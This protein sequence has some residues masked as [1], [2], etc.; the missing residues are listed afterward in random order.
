MTRARTSDDLLTDVRARVTAPA[1][2]GLLG[3]TE[4]L[5]LADEEMQTEISALLIGVR[6]EY[7][8]TSYTIAITSGV[9]SYRIP[10]RAAGMT[11]RDVTVYDANGNE[12]DANQYAADKRY[13]FTNASWAPG[14][15]FAFTLENGQLVL[16][17]TPAQSGYTL[18]L[19]YYS[20][21]SRLIAT[22]G[23]GLITAPTSTT[24]I[25]VSGSPPSTI[26]TT[27]ALVDIVRGDGMYEVLYE[28]RI[29]A[30]ELAGQI[31]FNSATPVVVSE[32][33]TSTTQNQRADYLCPSGYTVYPPIPDC[34]W[35]VLVSATCRAYCEAT[36]DMR[37]LEAAAV[38]FERR[39]KL[40]LDI[41]QPRVDS[42]PVQ[43]IP[44]DTPL[45]GS[46]GRYGWRW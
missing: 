27:G 21:P 39:K 6:S 12:W 24:V 37:G 22:S 8:L 18:R 36:A 7:W 31:T 42:Q 20:R 23:A 13:L 2:N 44:T 34:V 38:M 40:A 33:A 30:S 3:S 35:P 43:P 4:L 26:T 1:A 32:I 10:D 41:L 5:H 14:G 17:P 16:L 9:S 28:D 46:G 45:R 11:L 29:V 25:T 15:P 19:R